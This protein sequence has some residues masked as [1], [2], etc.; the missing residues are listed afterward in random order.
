[1]DSKRVTQGM[2]LGLGA[3]TVAA[4][5]TDPDFGKSRRTALAR[6]AGKFLK[7]AALVAADSLSD[8]E[9]RL[10]GVVAKVRR[11]F[12]Q[13]KTSDQVIEQRIRSRIGRVVSHPRKVHV[14]CDR[15][16]AT[17]W[18]LVL[19]QEA[20]RLIEA[21]KRVRGVREVVDQ[22]EI[23]APEQFAAVAPDPL[24]HA[25]EEIR[26]NWSPGKRLF[27][28][29]AGTALALRGWKR[30]DTLGKVMALC[31]AGMVVRSTMHK[32][33]MP[34]LAL[35]ESSPGFELEKT[36][37]IHAPISDLFDFWANPKNYPKAFSHIENIEQ[38]G[39]NLYEWTMAGPAGIPLKWQG[40]ITRSVPNTLIEW[41]SLPGS[42]VGN[43]GVVHF[44]PHYDASTRIH[45]RM[46]YRPPAGIFGRF[47]AEILGQDAPQ[48][49]DQD[50]KRLKYLFENGALVDRQSETNRLEAEL[51]KTATT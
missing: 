17:L 42:A 33:V 23:A 8:S 5:L 12:E 27:V 6:N 40:M 3:G 37:R 26:L 13:G 31:G 24:R 10:A 47:F 32:R 46:F 39:E 51:L 7:K 25:R 4:Y 44:D 49:L 43:F 22:L 2:L 38:L 20:S 29:A 50:L 34:T 19:E 30:N 41:K 35:T 21:V 45:I 36:I 9:H 16:V 14:L 48:I 28:G 15:S 1:M 11:N 18:G